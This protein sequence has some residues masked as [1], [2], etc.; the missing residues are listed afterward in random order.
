[1]GNLTT[2]KHPSVKP[3]MGFGCGAGVVLVCVCT[4][5]SMAALGVGHRASPVLGKCCTTELYPSHPLGLFE[6]KFC[7]VAQVSLQLGYIGQADL[8]HV[9]LLLQLH[10]CWVALCWVPCFLS[11]PLCPTSQSPSCPGHH[12]HHPPLQASSGLVSSKTSS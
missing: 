1:M 7:C 11:Q 12:H 9:I 6:A 10:E 2:S 4:C 3:S 5:L 8:K